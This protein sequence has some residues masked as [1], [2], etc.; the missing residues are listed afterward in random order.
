MSQE[1]KIDSK[2]ALEFLKRYVD[3]GYKNSGSVSIKE[4]AIL[5]KHFRDL[6]SGEGDKE[7]LYKI[8]IRTLEIFNTHKAYSL[9]DA[10]VIDIVITYVEENILK[11]KDSVHSSIEEVN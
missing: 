11:S 3:I 8:I 6:R 10:A 7:K 5:H 1:I 2:N 4:G 9:D